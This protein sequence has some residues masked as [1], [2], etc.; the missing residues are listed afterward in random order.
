MNKALKVTLT[1]LASL[2]AAFII[3]M[4]VLVW[5]VF[6]PSRLTPIVRS[7]LV[8]QLSC[9]TEIAEVELTFFSTFPNLDLKIKELKLINPLAGCPNDTLLSAQTSYFVLDIQALTRKNELLIKGIELKNLSV[10]TFTDK[11]GKTNYDVYLSDTSVKDTSAFKNPFRKISLKKLKLSNANITYLDLTANM[12]AVIRN[13]DANLK[14][15]MAENTVFADISA[16]TPS[17]FF[18]KDSTA[19][20]K[21][22]A[23][24]ISLPLS[25]QFDHKLL[26]IE[27]SKLILDG[28]KAGLNG[29]VQKYAENDNMLIDINL[30]TKPYSLKSLLKFVPSRYTSSLQG[31]TMDGT[32]SSVAKIKGVYNAT[33]MP[34][35]DIKAQLEKGNF[36]YSSLPFKLFDLSGFADVLV[37]MNHKAASRIVL[38]NVKAKTGQSDM[39]ASG[40]VDYIMLDDMLFD[41]NLKMN[42]NLCELKPLMPVDMN[43]GLNGFASGTGNL[44]FLQSDAMNRHFE[45]IKF[46]GEFAAQ[47]LEIN[48]D[49]LSMLSDNV[50]LEMSLPN[51][52]ASLTKFADA[53]FLCDRLLVHRGKNRSAS[54]LNAS[55]RAQSTNLMETE[56]LNT[57]NF[58]F[59]FDQ[60]SGSMDGMLANLDKS[61]GNMLLKMNFSDSISTP[62]VLCD[63]DV[64]KLKTQIDST[65]TA[66]IAYPKGQF[67]MYGQKGH[68]ENPVFDINGTTGNLNAVAGTKKV[69]AQS[70]NIN[71]NIQYDAAKEIKWVPTGNIALQKGKVVTDALKSPIDI[72]S[73]QLEFKPD[74][75]DIKDSHFVVDKSDFRLVGKLW[76]VDEYLKNK[77]LLKGDFNFDS[78]TTDVYQL[79][80]LTSG[81]GD[82]SLKTQ[83]TTTSSN[84]KN[85]SSGPYMVPKG[86]DIALHANVKQALLGFDTA[87]NVLGDLYIKDGILVLQD[88]RFRTSAAKMQ[89]TTMYKTPRKNHLFAGIDFHLTE[90]EIQEMLKIIPNIDSMMP[91]LRSFKGKGE[92]HIAVETYMDSS[93]NL[94]KSTLRGAASLQG[95]NLVLMD[96]ETFSEIAKTLRFNKKAENKVD[97]LSTE[98]TILKN[99]IDIY[100]FLIVMDKYKAVVAGRHNLDMSFNYHISVTDSPLPVKFGVNINGSMDELKKHPLKCIQPAPCKYA[101]LYSPVARKEVEMKKLELQKMIRQALRSEVKKQE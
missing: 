23:I 8:K 65:T 67:K 2:I 30:E 71:T 73:L 50:K 80:S 86:V 83:K 10:N 28:L 27:R 95:K 68:P 53:T 99:N 41:L 78:K 32:V 54:I 12:K 35:F 89:L 91:M 90:V 44:K 7:Q 55:M 15:D 100:P 81:F 22:S 63:F 39:E 42:L 75:Y 101:T 37:D 11:N 76:N 43:I 24:D 52:K 61:K 48:Y 85:T 34:L 14:V 94:K 3:T 36:E 6:T 92:F 45:K 69:M 93:Y 38:R 18:S 79:T 5:L 66:D 1:V 98:F 25:Y 17:L 62:N 97:S 20:L 72:P 26:L 58:D 59:N 74:S 46:N 82:D 4:S 77:G 64:S 21:N 29:S 49:S 47:R 84:E 57:M 70:M 40:T 51:K 96:G 16:T 9:K 60:M 33:S 56:K 13:L 31:M 88:L 87:R 19:Y